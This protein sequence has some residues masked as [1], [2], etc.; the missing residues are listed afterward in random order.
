MRCGLVRRDSG[1]ATSAVRIARA[2]R[3]ADTSVVGRPGRANIRRAQR[4]SRPKPVSAN[5]VHAGRAGVSHST[6]GSMGGQS[7]ERTA[8]RACAVAS[9]S[10]RTD[11][12]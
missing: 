3:L 9:S 8:S 10:G 5:A 7:S 4:G 6:L 11:S 12:R 1:T 2:D